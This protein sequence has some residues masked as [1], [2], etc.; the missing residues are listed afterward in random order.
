[1]E[2]SEISKIERALSIR[3]T[4]HVAPRSI[5]GDKQT[6]APVVEIAAA[7]RFERHPQQNAGQKMVF[8]SRN[9][10]TVRRAI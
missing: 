4:R 3:M 10:R 7:V 8:R 9:R 6:M 5:V 2:R 1:M